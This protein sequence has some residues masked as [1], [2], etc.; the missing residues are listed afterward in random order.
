MRLWRGLALLLLALLFI[1]PLARLLLLPLAVGSA[2]VESFRPFLNS[3]AFALLTGCIVAPLGALAAQALETKAGGAVRAL[4]L[5][6]WL[7]FFTPG[8]VLTTGWLVIFTHPLL[9]DSL[10]GQLFLGPAGLVFLYVLKA[11]PFAVFVARTT[12]A[13][14][15][16]S[17]REA[18]LVLRLPALRRLGLTMRLVLPAMAAAFAIAAIETMQEFGIPATLGVTT[19]IPILTYAIYQRLNTTP[20][21]F[22]GAALL[23]WWLIL[24]AGLLAALQIIIQRRF[25]AAL[26]HGKARRAPPVHPGGAARVV[27]SLAAALLWGVGIAGPFLALLSVAMQGTALDAEALSAI[28]RSLGYGVLAA[29][30]ALG[31][32][33]F[34]LKLQRGRSAW[35]T[36]AV[37][38]ALTANMAVPGLVLGA[39][40]V[41]AFNNDVL[42]LYGTALLLVIAYAAGALPVAA[43]LLGGAMAQLDTKLDE[44]A[45]IFGLNL[46]TRLIDIEGALLIRPALYAWLLVVGAVMFE[47][48]VS[49][50]LYVPGQMPL[51]VAIVSADMMANYDQAARLALLAM[52]VLAGLA[53]ILN[54][55]LHLAH[56]PSLRVR[57]RA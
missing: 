14:A 44:A 50:L 48:P 32:A 8:Y 41:V 3:A 21:D 23:C 51:G 45:R 46:Q 49:E 13:G 28:P 57:G 1:Y 11:L 30:L 43:R 38:G 26:V 10:P 33:A 25:H 47:L 5:G 34:V 22:A 6:L 24:S 29:T 17:L 37:Q 15:S 4:G 19:K 35:F 53:A 36:M 40:Y 12:F 27:L 54:L 9:R 56:A 20:T 16:I 55:A 42:P 18:A 52:G 31:A 7:L 39:G 2:S